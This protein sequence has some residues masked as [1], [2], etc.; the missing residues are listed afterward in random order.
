MG[1]DTEPSDFDLDNDYFFFFGL[2][3]SARGE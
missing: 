1:Q 2:G 3:D